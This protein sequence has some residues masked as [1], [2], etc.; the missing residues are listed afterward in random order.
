MKK[1]L[2]EDKKE[3]GV[4]RKIRHGILTA[5]LVIPMA[6][7]FVGCGND[8]APSNEPVNPNPP[9][10]NPIDPDKPIEPV[11]PVDPKPPVVE[12]GKE[13]EEAIENLYAFCDKMTSEKNYTYTTTNSNEHQTIKFGKDESSKE[14]VYVDDNGVVA[15]YYKDNE[16][17]FIVSQK[18]NEWHKNFADRFP[19]VVEITD[20]LV[21]EFKNTD[22]EYDED[23]KA[24]TSNNITLKLENDEIDMET[25]I[26]EVET[27]RTNISSVGTTKNAIPEKVIDDTV[28]SENI[29][30]IVNG[31]KVFNIAVMRDVIE[32]WLKNEGVPNQF[33]MDVLGKCR[34]IDELKTEKVVWVNASETE[35]K[36]GVLCSLNGRKI[37]SSYALDREQMY[38][39]I[40][41]GSCVSSSQ[42]RDELM[43][44]LRTRVIVDLDSEIDF[45]YTTLD[46]T[47][48]QKQEFNIVTQNSFNKLIKNGHGGVN[49]GV[50]ITELADSKVLFGFKTVN[51]EGNMKKHWNMQYVIQNQA[52]EIKFIDFEIAASTQ[53]ADNAIDHVLANDADWG[54]YSYNEMLLNAENASLFKNV[55]KNIEKSMEL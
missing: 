34:K 29:Y 19:D 37:Y 12:P 43:Q 23:S 28:Q 22:W 51:E 55:S 32:P 30:E 5:V 44:I 54:V 48:Q 27:I 1:V 11:D 14:I 33:G 10:I 47:E 4:L 16:D 31:Q 53:F 7:S 50:P 36:F 38:Q 17:K 24:L 25:S 2:K 20:S 49:G 6:L 45:D 21:G 3:T 26:S 35:I 9:I 8:K 40:A 41:N 15:Y 13:K 39:N 52:G 18:N 42:F 46:A